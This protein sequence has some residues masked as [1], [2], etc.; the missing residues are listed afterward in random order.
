MMSTGGAVGDHVRDAVVV[1]GGESTDPRSER[2]AHDRK[3]DAG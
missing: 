1:D 2:I 3:R